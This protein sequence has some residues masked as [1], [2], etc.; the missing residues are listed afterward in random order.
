MQTWFYR[1]EKSVQKPVNQECMQALHEY[2]TRIPR[3]SMHYPWTRDE[4]ITLGKLYVKAWGI[5]PIP[6]R[7]R[8]EYC[9]P[10]MATIQSL[11]GSYEA[12]YAAISASLQQ[13]VV[14]SQINIAR[15]EKIG[16]ALLQQTYDGF[17]RRTTKNP[18][19]KEQAV[20]LGILFFKAWKMM[21]KAG[22]LQSVYCMP[23]VRVIQHLFG[24]VEDF[25]N[26]ITHALENMP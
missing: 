7:M 25:H 5:M 4:C 19:T 22:R 16:M 10:S 24:S 6:N 2:Y 1:H 17:P 21:P 23:D 13:T 20:S 12:Y 8:K 11:F 15:V 18:W 14:Y 3:H 26:A 9:L